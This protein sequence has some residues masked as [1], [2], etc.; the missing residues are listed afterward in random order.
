[1]ISCLLN[2][3]SLGS[4]QWLFAK[5]YSTGWQLQQLL[6]ALIDAGDDPTVRTVLDRTGLA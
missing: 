5:L 2:N 4:S 1:L 6:I 3:L